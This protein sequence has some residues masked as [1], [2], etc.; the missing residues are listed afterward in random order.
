MLG[1]ARQ[2]SGTRRSAHELASETGDELRRRASA[3]VSANGL[4]RRAAPGLFAVSW[5]LD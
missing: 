4:P 2:G 5:K 3:R 1:F